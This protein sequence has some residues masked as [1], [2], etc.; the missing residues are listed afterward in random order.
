M[1]D[2]GSAYDWLKKISFTVRP[3]RI[4]TQI[5]VVTHFCSRFSDVISR[6]ETS[7]CVAKCRLFSQANMAPRSPFC[8]S[9]DSCRITILLAKRHL[10]SLQTTPCYASTLYGRQLRNLLLDQH[11]TIKTPIRLPFTYM[12]MGHPHNLRAQNRLPQKKGY[13][14]L[15]KQY[16]LKQASCVGLLV[17]SLLI[18]RRKQ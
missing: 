4:T 5:Q 17:R 1:T 15:I 14:C 3:I 8:I 13:V 10:Y 11:T 6:R 7:S 2:L 12:Y 9:S 16:S 18:D